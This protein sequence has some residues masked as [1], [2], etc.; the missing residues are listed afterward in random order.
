MSGRP[1]DGRRGVGALLRELADESA[2]LVRNEVRLARAEIA[3]ALDGVRDGTLRVAAGGVLVL[4]G[5]LSVLAGIVLLIGDQWLPRDL[6]WVGAL[7]V[8]AITGALA[9]W[10]A[11]RGMSLL[12]PPERAKNETPTTFIR[13]RRTHV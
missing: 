11:K 3:S 9:A 5:A 2:D 7:I 10:M 1:R 13:G 6:Y 8:A 4:L 12:S